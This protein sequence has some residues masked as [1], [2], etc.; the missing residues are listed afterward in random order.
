MTVFYF[1]LDIVGINAQIIY[2]G[3]SS[4]K[5]V[6]RTFLTEQ[7]I[8]LDKNHIQTRSTI[9]TLPKELRTKI[10]MIL[11]QPE[12]QPQELLRKNAM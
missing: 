12:R 4:E 11:G 7:G 1:L 6:R 10:R 8:S 2:E 3:N 5:S 9:V